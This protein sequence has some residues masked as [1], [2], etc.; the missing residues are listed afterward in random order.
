MLG[1]T[2]ASL[3]L[4]PSIHTKGQN[5]SSAKQLNLDISALP[6]GSNGGCD[7]HSN[8]I[9]MDDCQG[10]YYQSLVGFSIPYLIPT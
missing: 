10:G 1:M 7:I 5:C 4:K 8:E 6:M 2:L 9:Q 3:P